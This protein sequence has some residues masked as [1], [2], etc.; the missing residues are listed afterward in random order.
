MR[1]HQVLVRVALVFS[2]I[3]PCEC[4]CLPI[5][6]YNTCTFGCDA[7]PGP[8]HNHFEYIHICTGE[9]GSC[10]PKSELHKRLKTSLDA[11]QALTGF[12]GLDAT[13]RR[14]VHGTKVNIIVHNILIAMPKRW[15]SLDIPWPLTTF[16]P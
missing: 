12:N 14:L 9:M 2:F 11:R 1:D 10:V 4:A 5:I 8:T 16:K 6:F 15:M 3:V 13:I 7:S